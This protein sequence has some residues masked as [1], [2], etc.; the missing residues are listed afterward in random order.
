MIKRILVP[1]DFSEASLESLGH[2]VD[3]A[4]RYDGQLLLLHVVEPVYYAVPAIEVIA[5][6]KQFARAELIRLAQK[7]GEQGVTCHTL[8]R[9]GTPYL[10]IV[11]AARAN[12]ADVIVMA[13]HGRTGFSHLMMGSV[14]ERVV[15]TS[16]CPVLTVRSSRRAVDRVREEC[17]SEA[18][19]ELRA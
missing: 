11:D 18:R 3:L 2:A 15:R 16:V 14:A 17:G 8:L 10:E 6:Q 9:T 4:K 13:T 7:L 1:V 12:A 19:S 5:E